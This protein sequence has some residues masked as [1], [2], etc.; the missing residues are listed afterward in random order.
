MVECLAGTS[1]LQQQVDE[2]HPQ[3]H[4]VGPGA[5]RGGQAGQQ[6]RVHAH[7]ISLRSEDATRHELV[8]SLPT[9]DACAPAVDE[10]GAAE[11][12]EPPPAAVADA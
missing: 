6:P 7:G 11:E 10:R 5:D 12:P 3:G 9:A 1:R 2:V 8:I 4:I